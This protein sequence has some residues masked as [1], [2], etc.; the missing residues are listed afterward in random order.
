M[1]T[2]ATA[3]WK[4]FKPKAC[5][6]KLKATSQEELFDELVDVVVKGGLLP[7]D[8]AGDARAALEAREKMASTGVGKGVAIPHVKLAG[9]DRAVCSL[10]IHPEGVDWNALDGEPVQ[11]FF[12]VLRPDGETA[13]HDPERHLEMM[14]WI[15]R[16]ARHD[17]FRRFA[18]G[19]R[20][21][22][23]LVDLLKEMS[24]V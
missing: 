8:R 21:K 13:E 23:E 24:Q 10:S 18:I 7:E 2:D 20:K 14:R 6:I 22:T 11:I 5:S 1:P 17:D 3:A 15:S 19:A 9:L 12:T 16:L 4:L